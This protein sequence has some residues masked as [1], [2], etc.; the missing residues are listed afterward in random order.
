MKDEKIKEIL[1]RF[2]LKDKNPGS[3][4]QK[5][6]K[7]FNIGIHTY[8][9][10]GL[11]LIRV[12]KLSCYD[13][14]T[15]QDLSELEIPDFKCIKSWEPLPELLCPK[16]CTVCKGTGIEK[17]CRE[18]EGDGKLE[19]SSP[20]NDYTVDCESCDA[21]GKGD[22]ENRICDN[23]RGTKDDP[24]ETI[25]IKKVKISRVMIKKIKSLL[26]PKWKL[27]GPANLFPFIFD[28]GEGIG[29]PYIS[30]NDDK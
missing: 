10:D 12:Q 30:V 17:M 5:L 27:N 9:T 26:N 6:L 1:S 3:G 19:F 11:S 22:G 29:M 16:K 24:F 7:P 14:N 25:I 28:G 13:K 15:V 18:C 20:Y 2:C 8:A 23:C 4:R 21:S